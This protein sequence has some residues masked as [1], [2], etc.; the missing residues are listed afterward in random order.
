[1]ASPTL[2][3]CNCDRQG[4]PSAFVLLR[5]R[6]ECPRCR[7]QAFVVPMAMV[8]ADPSVQTGYEA[9]TAYYH[10]ASLIS[11]PADVQ[12]AKD[13]LRPYFAQTA[14]ATAECG[15]DASSLSAF[16]TALYGEWQAF[17]RKRPS[18][19]DASSDMSHATQLRMRLRAYQEQLL[20][21]CP[22]AQ[23]VLAPPPD[24]TLVDKLTRAGQ[25]AASGVKQTADSYAT[26][27]KVALVVGGAVAL[28]AVY[29]TMKNVGATTKLVLDNPDKF[30][31]IGA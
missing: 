20:A 23:L 15:S 9:V 5:D 4:P 19:L 7:A 18:Y 8:G 1:M 17:D 31:K 28:Y 30:A 13:A 24:A 29:K 2:K 11:G 14:Q 6:A 22:S 27:V 10:N 3:C 21:A 16:W 25:E 26:A 12:A